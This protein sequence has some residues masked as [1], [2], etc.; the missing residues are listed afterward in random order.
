MKHKHSTSK[1]SYLT[2]RHLNETTKSKPT[3]SGFH[4][5]KRPN[6][7][8][9]TEEATS[10]QPVNRLDRRKTLRRASRRWCSFWGSA[11]HCSSGKCFR[12][13]VSS[14]V[15]LR[16]WC[17]GFWWG[18]M[19]S[20]LLCCFCTRDLKRLKPGTYFKIRRDKIGVV[21]KKPITSGK[22][23]KSV[24]IVVRLK[25]RFLLKNKAVRKD[26]GVR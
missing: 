4:S 10:A 2:W 13:T 19:C 16:W 5:S 21:N 8:A 11:S 24:S 12:G 15:R 25:L 20:L 23:C 22:A 7:S 1:N 18:K 3:N 17:T 9:K 14:I 6:Q 26:L